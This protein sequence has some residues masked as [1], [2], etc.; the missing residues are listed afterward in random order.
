MYAWTGVHSILIAKPTTTELAE[1][2]HSLLRDSD[3]VTSF[4]S[5]LGD[6]LHDRHNATQVHIMWTLLALEVDLCVFTPGNGTVLH[7]A[8]VAALPISGCGSA[9]QGPRSCRLRATA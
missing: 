5:S 1:D 4:T 7:D 9:V 2:V 3:A 8:E 6:L